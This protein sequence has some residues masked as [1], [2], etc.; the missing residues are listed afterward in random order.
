MSGNNQTIGGLNN[1]TTRGIVEASETAN[2]Q[3]TTP[4]LAGSEDA[5]SPAAAAP[6]CATM[7]SGNSVL[8]IIKSGIGTQTLGGSNAYSG[9]TT[10]GGD[11]DVGSLAD[12]A[13]P[14]RYGQPDVRRRN[15]PSTPAALIP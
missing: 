3:S 11:P 1:A 5:A 8:S 2:G 7:P 13:R 9:G 14:G 12:G 4:T 6:D 10:I 15:P